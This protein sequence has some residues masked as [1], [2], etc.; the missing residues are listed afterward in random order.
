MNMLAAPP[1]AGDW[2]A[3]AT[4]QANQAQGKPQRL[5]AY[6]LKLKCTFITRGTKL[7]VLAGLREGMND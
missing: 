6:T 7:P 3:D 5:P 4:A 1:P 2:A